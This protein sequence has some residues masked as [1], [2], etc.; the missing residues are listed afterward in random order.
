MRSAL[1]ACVLAT[2]VAAPGGEQESEGIERVA[3]LEG[4][5]EMVSPQRTIEEQWMA[6]RG[7]SCSG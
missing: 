4:C 6:P 1:L 5:W 7:G 2:T 3:W